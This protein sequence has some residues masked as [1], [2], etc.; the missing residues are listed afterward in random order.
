M[1]LAVPPNSI[2]RQPSPHGGDTTT[3]NLIVAGEN[4]RIINGLKVGISLNMPAANGNQLI[5]L[6]TAPD[7]Q[8]GTVFN[9]T[10]DV[11]APLDWVNRTFNVNGLV[12]SELNGTLHSNHHRRREPTI[13][14]AH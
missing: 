5:I 9:G 8:Q 14:A 11:P 3:S 10:L 12:G 7:G 13:P 4:N 2:T 6:L 1:P